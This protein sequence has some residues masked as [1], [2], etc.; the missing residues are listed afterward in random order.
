M[1]MEPTI[2]ESVPKAPGALRTSNDSTT[3]STLPGHL[4]IPSFDSEKASNPILKAPAS[5]NVKPPISDSHHTRQRSSSQL[6]FTSG[7]TL[8]ELQ[9]D[10]ML[11]NHRRSSSINGLGT[12]HAISNTG[13]VQL[14][15]SVSSCNHQPQVFNLEIQ[16]RSSA[17]YSLQNPQQSVSNQQLT[18]QPNNSSQIL[19]KPIPIK[20]QP[21]PQGE[22]PCG[23]HLIQSVINSSSQT[24]IEPPLSLNKQIL[25]HVASHQAQ[26]SHYTANHQPLQGVQSSQGAHAFMPSSQ[27]GETCESKLHHLSTGS[28]VSLTQSQ[29]CISM[30]PS[31]VINQQQPQSINSMSVPP[32]QQ[33][34]SSFHQQQTLTMAGKQVQQ[35]AS[36]ILTQQIVHTQPPRQLVVQKTVTAQNH[37]AQQ[38]PNLQQSLPLNGLPKHQ[39]SPN[40]S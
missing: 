24:H 37:L 38:I 3:S 9:A 5:T 7:N 14:N 39:H 36:S 27:F 25:S 4:R 10:P 30:L 26:S 31:S 34:Q 21:L 35:Q 12:V 13:G 20:S 40:I 23:T 16:G 15:T 28:S 22:I 11:P 19:V 17:Q 6:A 18:P 33:N 2:S 29:G 32:H 1:S 8:D